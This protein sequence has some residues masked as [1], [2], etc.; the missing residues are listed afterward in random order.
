M[1]EYKQMR[2]KSSFSS[3]F[4]LL[5]SLSVECTIY[6][7]LNFVHLPDYVLLKE[8]MKKIFATL[9]VF[10]S[11]FTFSQTCNL[12]N[13]SCNNTTGLFTSGITANAGS[14]LACTTGNY[15]LYSSS[16]GKVPVTRALPR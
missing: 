16:S 2:K 10:A 6:K 5:V 13:H 12:L 7:S 8:S 1:Q 14:T 9:V 4:F 11:A 15:V 3:V